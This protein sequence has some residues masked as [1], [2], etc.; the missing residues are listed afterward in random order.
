[1]QSLKQIFLSSE[2][3]ELSFAG[4]LLLESAVGNRLPEC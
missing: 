4:I 2:K 1:M 3:I